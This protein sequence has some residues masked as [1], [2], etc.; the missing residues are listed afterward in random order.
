[1]VAAEALLVLVV[2]EHKLVDPTRE[3]HQQVDLR[4]MDM[5]VD[6]VAVDQLAE[7]QEAVELEETLQQ[8]TELEMVEYHVHF[9]CL[10]QQQIMQ[11]VEVV[12]QLHQTE[13]QKAVQFMLES[14]EA[15]ALVQDLLATIKHRQ[16][17]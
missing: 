9:Q 10:E 14:A 15:L 7:V 13:Q 1:L 2:E 12:A 16:Q 5:L 6:L 3:A 8:L 17:A 11:A 4:R